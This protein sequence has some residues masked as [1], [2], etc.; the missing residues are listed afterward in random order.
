LGNSQPSLRFGF[1]AW[2]LLVLLAG[3]A[4]ARPASA[5]APVRFEYQAPSECPSE[6]QFIDAVRAR[7]ARARLAAPGEVA[8]R[9]SVTLSNDPAGASGRVDFVDSDGIP[10]FRSIVGSTCSE[11]MIGIA[12]VSALACDAQA[13]AEDTSDAQPKPAQEPAPERSGEGSTRGA[14]KG[15]ESPAPPP[16]GATRAKR[17]ASS[18]ASEQ[19]FGQAPRPS[20]AEAGFGYDAGAGAGY[21]SHQGPSG[22]LALDAFF[23]VRRFFRSA[24]ARAS[25]WHFR[26]ETDTDGR[27]ARFRGYGLRLEGCPLALAG[28]SWW[29]EPCLGVDGGAVVA[30]G[31]ASADVVHPRRSWNG[32]SDLVGIA[33]LG[34]AVS[35]WLLLD[36]QGELALSL[37]R[38]RYGFGGSGA[39]SDV[40]EV[41]TLGGAIRAHLGVRFR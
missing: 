9:F 10:A 2:P 37:V 29:L 13:S 22:A 6:A 32:F 39:E 17:T 40:F 31:V 41:P 35:G 25:L 1:R 34:S 21:A 24:S 11:V 19:R 8:L 4:V 7:L 26:S 18:A 38:Y 23:G 5:S 14:P 30:S 27:Q 33:R 20:S 36:L 16:T 12:L 3:L 28:S 15:P